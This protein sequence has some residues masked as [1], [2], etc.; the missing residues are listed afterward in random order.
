MR[1]LVLSGPNGGGLRTKLVRML[2][3]DGH[4]VC[5]PRE[6][7]V[8]AAW[9]QVDPAWKS[10]T[11]AELVQTLRG[12]RADAFAAWHKELLRPP[13]TA[14]AIVP[15]DGG[16]AVLSRKPV[17]PGA[18]AFNVETY[19]R[20]TVA[21]ARRSLLAALDAAD[22]IVLVEPSDR[23]ACLAFG[24]ALGIAAAS[25]KLVRSA[26][27]LLPADGREAPT[28]MLGWSPHHF[29][30]TG[31]VTCDVQE[32]GRGLRRQERMSNMSSFSGS[33]RVNLFERWPDMDVGLQFNAGWNEANYDGQRTD[34]DATACWATQLV[35]A[36][37]ARL[38]GNAGANKLADMRTWLSD[39]AVDAQGRRP[40]QGRYVSG[41]TLRTDY[42]YWSPPPAADYAVMQPYELPDLW[43]PGDTARPYWDVTSA[44]G[45][46]AWVRDVLRTTI[47]DGWPVLTIDNFSRGQHLS[48]SIADADWDAGQLA[49]LTELYA[50]LEKGGRPLRVVVNVAA[51]PAAALL[52]FVGVT[53]GLLF[54]SPLHDNVIAGGGGDVAA[55][56]AVYRTVLDAGLFMGL[57]PRN[58]GG[59]TTPQKIAEQR[60]CAGAAMLI[61][62]PG[63]ALCVSMSDAAPVT[64]DWFTWKATLGWPLGAYTR[65]GLVF[66]REFVNGT[67]TVD[68]GAKTAVVTT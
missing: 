54:E 2:R 29:S 37:Q 19:R 68:F 12:E 51:N 58:V 33:P 25:E 49:L 46:S 63:D 64:Y 20:D 16:A 24:A 23:N 52:D 55:E 1:V 32:I 39:R 65:S 22:A 17:L 11:N 40:L 10:W 36:T 47:Q 61:W 6:S 3:A 48:L 30:A 5:D 53:D 18:Q 7:D 31:G 56:L 67:L 13:A 42:P 44:A 35:W 14:A 62:K 38:V 21:E 43:T 26:W 50:E 57:V 66:T 60:M 34:P 28:L 15:G 8:D 59:W 9:R 27:V 45:R 4:A 41:T